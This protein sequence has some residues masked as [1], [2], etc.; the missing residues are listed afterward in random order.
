[1]LQLISIDFIHNVI[2]VSKYRPHCYVLA[3]GI[4][5]PILLGISSFAAAQSKPVQPMLQPYFNYALTADD[6]ILRLRTL[7]LNRPEEAFPDNPQLVALIRQGKIAD[8]TNR[9]TG[10]IQ[11]DKTISRQRFTADFNYTYTKF[12]RF[13]FMNTNL[14]S[15]NG[16]WN[17]VLGNYLEGNMGASYVQS[18][19][20]L[21]FIPGTQVIRT[22]QTQFF[23]GA[24]RFHP[25]WSLHG[26]YT[27]YSLDTKSNNAL[28]GFNRFRFLER[29]ENRFEGGIDY[30]TANKNT[31]GVFFRAIL[32]DFSLPLSEINPANPNISGSND[33]TQIEAMGKINWHLTE[34]SR[35][36][37]TGGWVDRSNASFKQRDFSGFNARGTYY[38]QP[39][40]KLGLAV[41]G[42][43]L[44]NSMN[45][46][47]AN[48]GINTGVNLVP[49]WN[50]TEKVRFEGEFSYET[51]NFNRFS[52]VTDSVIPV[53]R[54][55]TFRNAALR[56]IYSPYLGLQLN[57]S[58]YHTDLDTDAER[59]GQ[60]T[61]GYNANGA[62]IG[63]QYVYGKR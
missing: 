62:S 63:L 55:N 12:E 43:R 24:W 60:R 9:I 37:L 34:K 18:L 8:L 23:N 4:L 6:N 59:G 15:T 3:S 41:S 5:L 13:S 58:I 2:F 17:W 20:P 31:V 14:I 47:T 53:G 42:W 28:T 50:I 56:L 29:T 26:E 21:I 51:R 36:L 32:G 40:E 11:F 39:T 33:F 45:N 25:S 1:M 57:A 38:W 49:Y 22:E 35:V 54:H 48:F 19:L 52:V 44:T 10:G 7:F 30:I 61:G 16:N 46:L 27:H